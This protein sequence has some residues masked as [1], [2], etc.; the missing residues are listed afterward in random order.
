MSLEQSPIKGAELLHGDPDRVAVLF[1]LHELLANDNVLS[2][3]YVGKGKD[4]HLYR[5]MLVEPVTVIRSTQEIS[6]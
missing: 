6:R 5:A 2:V 4:G 3:E 1:V